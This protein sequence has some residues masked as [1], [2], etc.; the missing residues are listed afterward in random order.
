MKLSD[1]IKHAEDLSFEIIGLMPAHPLEETAA[2]LAKRKA[3]GAEVEFEERNLALRTNPQRV[4]DRAQSILVIGMPSLV[5]PQPKNTDPMRGTVSIFAVGQDYHTHFRRSLSVFLDRLKA[6]GIGA[7][8]Q[9]DTGPLLERAFARAAGAGF[10]GKNTTII[11][12]KWGSMMF[13]GLILVDVQVEGS[14]DAIVDGCG[15]CS[16]CQK[17]CPMGALDEAYRMDISRCLSYW[18]QA[19]GFVPFEI[20]LRWGDRIYGCDQCQLVCPKNQAPSNLGQAAFKSG[21]VPFES[22]QWPSWEAAHPVLIEV[23]EM[24]KAGFKDRFAHTAAGWR[25][26]NLLRRNALMA[27]ARPACKSVFDRVARLLADPSPMV[28]AAAGWTLVQM[29]QEGG[30]VAVR[31]A[32]REEKDSDVRHEWTLVLGGKSFS[33]MTE[34]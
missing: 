26:R 17:A 1:L 4:D 16:L 2:F 22:G 27:L 24:D 12:P 18:T 31:E 15:D 7:T 19:K 28:R 21:Q 3:A 5:P 13:L 29:D 23:A 8:V 11:H 34:V 30:R 6:E 25:G 32:L 14:F 33:K 20:R 9:V 10:Q